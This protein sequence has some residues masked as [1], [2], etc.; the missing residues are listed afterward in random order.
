MELSLIKSFSSEKTREFWET[1]KSKR[2][3]AG[4][5]RA[6]AKRKLDMVNAAVLLEDLKIPLGNKLHRLA[7]DR[8]GQHAIWINDQYRVCFLWKDG[9]AYDVEIVDYH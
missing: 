9:N 6:A 8:A 5:L 7:G 1:G 4:N 2:V 3:P